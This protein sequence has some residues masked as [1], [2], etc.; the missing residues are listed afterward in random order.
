[1]RRFLPALGALLLAPLLIASPSFAATDGPV[2]PAAGKLSVEGHGYGHGIGMSQYGAYGAALKGL[3]YPK[4]LSYYYPGTALGTKVAKIR[5]L[6]S[7]DTTKSVIVKARSDLSFYD[8][9]TK[10]TVA[11]PAMIGTYKTTYWRIM[12]RATNPMHSVV[13]YKAASG[14]KTYKSTILTGNGQFQAPHGGILQLVM[15]DGSLVSYR[16]KLRSAKPTTTSTTRRTVNVLTLERYLRGVV[17]REMPTSWKAEALRAQA[18]AA[19]TYGARAIRTAS[20]YDICD[21]TSCQV[22]GGVADEA[23]NSD[24]AVAATAGKVLTYKGDLAFTQ[25]SSSSGGFTVKGSQPYL[26]AKADAYDDTPSNS[27]HDW[28]LSVKASTI[29]AKYPGIGTLKTVQVTKRSGGG[30]WGGR[31]SSL[32]LVGS[33]GSTTIS[34]ETARFAFGLYSTWFAFN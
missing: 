2:A 23:K 3:T 22:Y 13:A 27:R 33:K 24:A 30:E 11:L 26:A 9:T 20:Y 21:T 34:G 6:V 17:A 4:I 7:A 1:M 16:G 8:L 31:V 12:P 28:K 29:E 14:W 32:K 15:P 5:V 18:V 19:R 25:F 10:K